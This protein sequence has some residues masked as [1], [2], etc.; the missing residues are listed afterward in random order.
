MSKGEKYSDDVR[1]AIKK[2][3]CEGWRST[4]IATAIN[5][6]FPELLGR[7]NASA[8]RLIAMR[9]GLERRKAGMAD[10]TWGQEARLEIAAKKKTNEN[11]AI[12]SLG[13]GKCKWPI[14][15]VGDADFGFC[16]AKQREGSAYCQEH[17]AIAYRP[18]SKW[19]RWERNAEK[20]VQIYGGLA[21]GNQ[22]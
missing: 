5:N 13:I 17:H 9:M 15:D 18:R 22:N 20:V 8:V 11:D 16:C 1:E 10:W 21:H 14:G 4:N 7:M 12:D 19:E 6:N 3:W 2:L